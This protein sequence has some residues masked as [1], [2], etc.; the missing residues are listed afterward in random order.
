MANLNIP[1]IQ[2]NTTAESNDVNSIKNSIVNEFN[3]NIDASNISDGAITNQKLADDSVTSGKIGNGEVKTVNVE[4]GSITSDKLSS[5]V[6]FRAYRTAAFNITGGGGPEIVPFN[7]ESYDLGSNYST[8]TYKFTA[9]YD[10]IYNFFLQYRANDIDANGALVAYLYINGS[11]AALSSVYSAVSTQ[12]WNSSTG[13][14]FQLTAGDEVEPWVD[15]T[16]TEALSAGA[17]TS[18]FCGHLVG[19]TD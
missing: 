15:C 13:G 4:D 8:S 16:T 5:T 2:G 18:F 1:D 19:R 3:G 14:D 7:L 6:A 17:T 9:P 10:G 11:S 12:D